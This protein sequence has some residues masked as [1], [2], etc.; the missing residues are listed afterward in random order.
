M[1]FNSYEFILLFFP[2]A[3]IAYHL[4]VRF[5]KELTAKI[6]LLI[7]SS[8][9]ICAFD[10]TSFA[11][12]L[13]SLAINYAINF[14]LTKSKSKKLLILGIVF[15]VLYLCVFK[16]A[17]TVFS[18]INSP[19]SILL[20][21]G[22]SFYTFQQIAYLVDGYKKYL[23][24][25]SFI[26]YA[27][28]VTFFPKFIQGPI[29]LREDFMPQLKSAIGHGMD[30]GNIFN[31]LA[32]FAVGLGKKVLIADTF[33]KIVDYGHGTVA[34]L[35][36][37]EA[38]IVILG[39]TFQLYFDFSGYCDMAIGLGRMFNFSLPRNFD[40]PYKAL[41]ISDFWKRWH[42]TLTSFLTKYIYFPLG[43]NRK[44]TARTYLN[45]MVIYIISGL[46]HGTGTTFLFWGI[47]HGLASILYRATKKQYDKFPRIIKWSLTFIFIN[48]TWVF[49]R[50]H[51][52][53]DGFM[54]IRRV[55]EGGKEFSINAELTETLLQPTLLSIPSQIIGLNITV[56]L[57]FV[58]ALCL[59]LFTKNSE[60]IAENRKPT[61]L[62]WIFTYTILMISILSLSGVST[63]LYSNF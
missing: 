51:S 33:A 46:W 1:V 11:V 19:F 44:G 29:I 9:F 6:I 34:T 15:N 22:I 3:F 30:F 13:L 14:G 42:I 23:S 12:L 40:S 47:L 18:F 63:F 28:F 32:T 62:N 4:A 56:V 24:A 38:L 20:P 26:D 16:Y 17:N 10:I 52:I 27:L 53:N 31:G 48:F 37:F 2:F 41:N 61:I 57:G 60:E 39:Y 7:A 59:V 21:V 25:D 54:L 45:I 43:G 49:F 58:A 8:I 50:S 36:S 5:S 35:N 55:F